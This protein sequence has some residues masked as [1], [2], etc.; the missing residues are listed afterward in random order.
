MTIMQL[1]KRS[2]AL[3]LGVCLPFCATAKSAG[4]ADASR[5]PQKSI[6]ILYENDVHC[7]IDG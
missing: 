4:K 3:L 7:A 6:V 2:A 5:K 1:G